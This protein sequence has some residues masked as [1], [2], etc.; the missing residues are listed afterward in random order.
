M[1]CAAV[2]L[3]QGLT[4]QCIPRSGIEGD[5]MKLAAKYDVEAPATFVFAQLADFDGWERAAMRRGA[6][7]TDTLRAVG[8]GMSW[9]TTFQYRAKERHATIRL[10]TINP[11]S[12]LAL[13]GM[14]ALLDGVLSIEILDLA[15][16]RTR[17][18]VRLEMKPKTIA[19]RIYVQS[20]RLARS[21]VERSFAQ[22]VA[23]L[24]VEIE[25]RFKRGQR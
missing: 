19:A 4:K 16:K 22:K 5:K 21:R 3:W 17:I 24:T 6:D 25:D 15:A 18:E 12:S 10:D 11:T 7:V 23:Q 8:P 20:L 9:A 13:T 2:G 14:S 1:P